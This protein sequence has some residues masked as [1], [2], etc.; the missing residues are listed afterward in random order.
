MVWLEAVLN[1]PPVPD[2][3]LQIDI[4]IGGEFAARG[5]WV[6]PQVVELVWSGPALDV[7]GLRLKVI[8]TSSVE[9]VPELFDM[10]QRRQYLPPPRPYKVEVWLEALLK[11]PPVPDTTLHIPIP[12]AGELAASVT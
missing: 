6:A 9:S 5:T 10:H 7:V 12:I 2:T 8:T 11:D 1:D 4:P 3:T